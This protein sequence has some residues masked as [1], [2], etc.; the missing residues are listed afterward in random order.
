MRVLLSVVFRRRRQLFALGLALALLSAALTDGLAYSFVWATGL[1]Y[2]A[3]LLFAAYL[4]GSAVAV[5]GSDVPALAAEPWPGAGGIGW[6]SLLWPALLGV[7]TLDAL[8]M[9]CNRLPNVLADRLA[10]NLVGCL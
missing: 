8:A 9:V 2:A 10:V 3:L 6:R 1:R 5:L 4:V 7:L